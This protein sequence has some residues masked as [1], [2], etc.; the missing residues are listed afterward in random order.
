MSFFCLLVALVLAPV[1]FGQSAE[2]QAEAEAAE[3]LLLALLAADWHV[4]I[5]LPVDT[6]TET[7]TTKVREQARWTHHI[8]RNK[9]MWTSEKY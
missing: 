7:A 3:R 6:S 4:P 1:C 5:S 2:V 9:M 8:Y